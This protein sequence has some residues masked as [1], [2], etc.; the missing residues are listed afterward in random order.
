MSGFNEDTNLQSREEKIIN[1]RWK[2]TPRS[3]IGRG[4]FSKVYSGIDLQTDLKVAIK[5]INLSTASDILKSR[6]SEEIRIITSLDHPNVVKTYDVGF[7][8]QDRNI[9]VYIIMEH[10]S[11][12]DFA[13]FINRH[14]MKELKVR[15][16]LHQLMK[17]LAYL[18]ERSILHRDLKPANLL[19]SD[20]NQI[21][22]IAD[23]G[24]AR[25]LEDARMTQT[26]CGSPLYMA[27]EVLFGQSYNGKSDLWSIGVILYQCIYGKMPFDG[28]IDYAQLLAF[29]REKTITYPKNIHISPECTDLLYRLLQK[30]PQNRLDWDSFF[31]HRWWNPERI[32]SL[33]TSLPSL[34]LKE[35]LQ[36]ED[37]P[38]MEE[39]FSF[40]AGSPTGR[41]DLD[42]SGR[43]LDF[44]GQ[45]S[46]I[47]GSFYRS[48]EQ[49]RPVARS[50]PISI[51]QQGDQQQIS[52]SFSPH[53]MDNYQACS[54]PGMIKSEPNN[55]TQINTSIGSGISIQNSGSNLSDP[56]QEEKY[57]SYLWSMISSSLRSFSV[58]KN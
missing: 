54:P 32:S 48:V 31:Y 13:K 27:P 53:V 18:R 4:Q 44:S 26:M 36:R 55:P 41:L 29:L 14:P 35:G 11:G 24:F 7:D 58:F 16:Y 12:G 2:F 46:R 25:Y 1:Q 30:N 17:G 6:V 51:R 40:I 5:K 33:S 52:I 19:L 47:S 3:A 50:N 42:R 49:H 57:T 20:D 28:V 34:R 45:K 8:E 38:E 56:P 23:F 39:D 22:K 10:C 15:Y 21:L 43:D 9:I 37:F